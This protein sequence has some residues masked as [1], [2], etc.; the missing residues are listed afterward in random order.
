MPRQSGS[1]VRYRLQQAKRAVAAK[2]PW[3]LLLAGL[4]LL[5]T[6]L[7]NIYLWQDEAETALLSQRLGTY[8]LPLAFDGRNLIRQAPMDIQYTADYV[9]VYHPWLPFYSTTL[10]FK[11]FGRTTFAARLPYALA[12]LGTVLLLY[13]SVR[14]H[15]RDQRLAMLSSA[16]LLLSVPFLL[17]ARQCKYFPFAALFTVATLDAYLRLLRAHHTPRPEHVREHRP[18]TERG[19]ECRAE[20]RLALPYL[21]LAGFCL[22]QSNFGAFLPLFVALGLHFIL[23]RPN[24]S[25]VKHMALAFATVGFFVAPWGVYL[26]AWARGRFVFDI[27][28]FVGHLA[29][30]T[31]YITGWVL[32]WPLLFLF[33]Y[34]YWRRLRSLRLQ[35]PGPAHPADPVGCSSD[36]GDAGWSTETSTLN[37]YILVILIT[38][39]FLSATFI[40]MYFS[41]IVQLVPLLMVIVAATIL[42][43][44]DRWRALGYVLLTL[45]VATNILHVF[46]YALPLARSFKWA[47]LAPRPY[48]AET[49]A[50]IATA[51]RLHFYLADYAYELTHDYDGPDEGIVLYL[52]AHAAPE[53]IVLTNYGELPI[54]F[55]TGLHIAG[56]L[57]TYRLEELTSPEWIIN[58]RDGPY[59]DELARIIAEGN[60]TASAIPYP[61]ILWGNRPVPE[62]HKFATVRDVPDVI[63]HRR[64]D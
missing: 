52:Q 13:H 44:T 47:S 60:Y 58:R 34:F 9:W 19:M 39:P 32:P 61:D 31:V 15:F 37:L 54:A 3:L 35:S 22:F 49:D 29:H 25:Q 18:R 63:I 59:S 16:L 8:G 14:R 55:Y 7:G 30:Y 2:F 4:V 20:A 41:Y 64:V 51:G 11:L 10:S 38:L 62:Y 46:P 40:W 48:L 26:Q 43:V 17:H 23:S 57:G 12:G 56:G 27:Y 50:L 28:R 53:D 33:A 42:C 24:R 5:L 6:N 1:A 21:I 36:S 45:L